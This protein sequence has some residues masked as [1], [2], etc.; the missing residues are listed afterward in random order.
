MKFDTF[1]EKIFD[2]FKT[3]SN[4]CVSAG[5]DTNL[6]NLPDIGKN[7]YLKKTAK[8]Q[9]LLNTIK[10]INPDDLN[11]DERIDLELSGQLLLREKTFLEMTIDG[12]LVYF[13]MP[14]AAP[15]IVDPLFYL[16]ATDPR[17]PKYR[18]VNVLTRIEQIPQFLSQ[19]QQIYQKPVERWVKIELSQLREIPSFFDSLLGWAESTQFN[20]YEKLQKSIQAANASIQKYQTYLESASTTKNIF[21]GP[22]QTQNVLNS[23]GIKLSF[24][25]LFDIAK[26]F[27]KDTFAKIDELKDIIIK[28]YELKAESTIEEVDEFLKAKYKVQRPVD[29]KGFQYV[30]DY[31][32]NEASKIEAFLKDKNLFPIMDDQEMMI[33]Q[34]PKF[35]EAV[36]PAGAM[37]PPPSFR[38]GNKKSIVYLTLKEELLDEHCTLSIPIMMVHEGIPGHHLQLSWAANNPSVIRKLTMA[39][40]LAEGWTTMLEDYMVDV[41]YI[42]ENKDEVVFLGKRDLSRL[43]ARVAIDLYFMTGEKKYL[44]I[45][46][47]LTFDS[48]D[49]F[50][51][52]GKLLQYL[53][54][55][56][57]ARVQAEL[58]WYSQERGYPLS[59][60]TGNHLVNNLKKKFLEQGKGDDQ[61]FHEA[62]LKAGNMPVS[63]LEKVLL[64]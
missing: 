53:T 7:N 55:F 12:E 27:N 26:N 9:T 29:S 19:A 34:T 3:D 64:N 52:A 2:Y 15:M 20:G 60:L 1:V 51:N 22:E 40:D 41:G 61:A 42:S 23:A 38:T 6:G 14:K 28:K 50:V 4:F 39:N 63:V 10:E 49:P 8:V 56:T 33:I 36:I 24:D 30:L 62:Y 47:N 11:Q 54:G 5:L 58:N 17:E 59:Y 46:D 25:E 35:M 13:K 32:E 44:Q 18:L 43:G 37:C 57:D 21:I 48:E 16:F 45:V 31:Y